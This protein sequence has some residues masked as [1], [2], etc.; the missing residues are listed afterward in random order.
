MRGRNERGGGGC[1]PLALPSGF[2]T[3]TRWCRWWR[4]KGAR[5]H[6]ASDRRR[7]H[8]W[9]SALYL[10]ACVC[11]PTRSSTDAYVTRGYPR[12]YP[13]GLLRQWRLIMRQITSHNRSNFPRRLP[14]LGT[15]LILHGLCCLHRET[16]RAFLIPGVPLTAT[17]CDIV[18][19]IQLSL[20]RIRKRKMI[21]SNDESRS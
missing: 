16:T 19:L 7:A 18:N 4:R 6:F 15:R 10:R 12:G 3:G 5:G 14:R 1:N 20:L 9:Y 2:C 13:R 21:G 8:A 11:K 17:R